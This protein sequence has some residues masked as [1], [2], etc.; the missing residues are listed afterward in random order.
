M[1]RRLRPSGVALGAREL[2]VR[3]QPAGAGAAQRQS[4]GREVP[5]GGAPGRLWGGARDADPARVLS[6]APGRLGAP[7]AR[8][9]V[10]RGGRERGG[11]RGRRIAVDRLHGGANEARPA[12]VVSRAWPAP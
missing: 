8:D 7:E 10:V 9:A 2:S 5:G 11:D 1:K 3:L 4:P 6:P 12:T